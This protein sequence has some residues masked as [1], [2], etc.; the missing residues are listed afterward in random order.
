MPEL[1]DPATPH[2]HFK[3]FWPLVIIFVIASILGGLVY[4]FQFSLSTDYDLQSMVF[5]VH[6]RTEQRLNG[7]T[8]TTTVKTQTTATP[9][10]TK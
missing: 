4:W 9:T 6:R 3:A 5:T 2:K 10:T 8:K 1:N 7:S